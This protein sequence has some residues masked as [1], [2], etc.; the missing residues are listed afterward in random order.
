MLCLRWQN[1][2]HWFDES[3]RASQRDAFEHLIDL[4]A[5]KPFVTDNRYALCD[6]CGLHTAQV[7]G[8][9]GSLELN[10]PQ[11]GPVQVR[12]EQ[13]K[14]WVVDESWVIR[15]LRGALDISI[16]DPSIAITHDIWRL[17]QYQRRPVFL[18][19]RF[20]SV[21]HQP[22]V[23]ARASGA[24]MPWLITAKS[25]RKIE[26][27]P[28]PGSCNWLPMQERFTLYGASLSVLEPG[29]R[30]GLA[31]DMTQAVH[32]VFSEDFRWANNHN[33][34]GWSGEPIAL[35]VAQAKVFKALWHFAGKPQEA[36]TIMSHAGLSSD[37]PIDV[38]KVKPKNKGDIRF[39]AALS[40]YK[41]LVQTD[42][43]AGTY[44]MACAAT[45]LPG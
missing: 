31:T 39:E 36:H 10:C 29:V 21:L 24:A 28:A 12:P 37:K 22:S 26:S 15:K 9:G 45:T 8:Q 27:E 44:A 23:I 16:Q 40:T 13:F 4:K 25:M 33:R 7:F 11:C 38:F 30:A 17:G 43:R 35:S 20:D 32:G 2:G 34:D 18:A 41:Q 42:R 3:V 14:A 19:R 6:Y 5:L 1:P